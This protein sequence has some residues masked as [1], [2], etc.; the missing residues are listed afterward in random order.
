M[1]DTANEIT[2]EF[3]IE[4]GTGET[5]GFVEL[6]DFEYNPDLIRV[7]TEKLE[8]TGEM[9]VQYGDILNFTVLSGDLGIKILYFN[10]KYS[11]DALE[12]LINNIYNTIWTTSNL[13]KHS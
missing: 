4:S 5:K 13:T 11:H 2:E 8:E 12:L 1:K 7:E 3:N 9:G 10:D 6:F